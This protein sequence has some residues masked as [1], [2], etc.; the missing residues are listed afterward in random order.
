M[1]LRPSACALAL[2]A[3]VLLT[4]LRS[5]LAWNYEGHMIVGEIAYQQLD[6]A[7]K[8]ALTRLLKAHPHYTTYLTIGAPTAGPAQDEMAFVRAATW[9]DA[10][11]PSRAPYKPL[12]IDPTDERNVTQYHHPEWHY[13]DIAYVLPGDANMNLQ[14]KAMSTE[15]GDVVT[16]IREK[17]ADFEK[18]DTTDKTNG[19]KNKAIDLAWLMHGVGDMHQP[20]HAVTL[21]GDGFAPPDGDRGGNG[22][23]VGYQSA[24]G[25]EMVTNLHSFW[26]GALGTV[27]M[28]QFTVD[29]LPALR[30]RAKEIM[31]KHPLAS[32]PQMKTHLTPESWAEESYEAAKKSAYLNGDILKLPKPRTSYQL[33]PDYVPHAQEV[34]EERAALAGYR[35]AALL[36]AELKGQPLPSASTPIV[37]A[38]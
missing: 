19:D 20:L 8:A 13:I 2:L 32:L 7:D 24:A 31:T 35:L 34:A 16:M 11:R 36:H 4:P 22:I 10:V 14:H 9:P 17:S 15:K 3:A 26:D 27:Q 6:D 25:K 23:L 38:K 21:I 12:I 28:E 33:P 29:S 30:A 5:A 1:Q 37:P 18:K